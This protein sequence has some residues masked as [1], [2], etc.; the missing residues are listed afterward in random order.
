MCAPTS[1]TG[2]RSWQSMVPDAGAPDDAS[3]R[4]SRAIRTDC[5]GHDRPEDLPV[6]V[7]HVVA[8]IVGRVEVEA[9]HETSRTAQAYADERTSISAATLRGPS[10]LAGFHSNS[11]CCHLPSGGRRSLRTKEGHAQRRAQGAAKS[12]PLR[13]CT[14]P[15]LSS[16][17]ARGVLPRVSPVGRR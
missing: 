16:R 3:V 10:V 2:D 14:L 5:H 6:A 9:L 4:A 8:D 11:L 12:G 17:D 15:S 13:P 1:T 7:G